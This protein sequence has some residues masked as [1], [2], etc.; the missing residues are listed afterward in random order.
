MVDSLSST[1]SPD[2]RD[3]MELDCQPVAAASAGVPGV[4]ADLTQIA[5]S[6][7]ESYQAA[8]PWPHVVLDDLIDPAL[9]AAAEQEELEPSL[10]LADRA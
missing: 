6:H 1:H 3:L 8:S 7:A 2:P 4:A 9:I 10:N 5:R